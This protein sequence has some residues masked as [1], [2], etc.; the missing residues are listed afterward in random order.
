MLV[1]Q[2]SSWSDC[3]RDCAPRS[4]TWRATLAI[5]A[6]RSQGLCRQGCQRQGCLKRGTRSGGHFAVNSIAQTCSFRS[7]V[8]RLSMNSSDREVHGSCSARTAQL[9][10]P[11]LPN[12]CRDRN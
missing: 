3:V 4:V 10:C 11:Q 6:K 8:H 9:S 2:G 1:P 5:W 12:S 7:S